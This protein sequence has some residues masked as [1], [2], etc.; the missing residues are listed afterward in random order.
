M[1]SLVTIAASHNA[2]A[3]RFSARDSGPLGGRLGLRFLLVFL[4]ELGLPDG[5]DDLD[6]FTFLIGLGLPGCL[7]GLGLRAFLVGELGRA[8][9]FAALRS[10]AVFAILAGDDLWCSLIS[11]KDLWRPRSRQ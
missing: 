8:G 1:T 2:A 6:L 4:G 10:G 11:S 7:D 9:N 3:S 5:L